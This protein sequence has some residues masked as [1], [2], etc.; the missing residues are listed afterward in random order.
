M[1]TWKQFYVEH[2]KGK[3]IKKGELGQHM[4]K[5]GEM[6]R[7]MKSKKGGEVE[8]VPDELKDTAIE[9]GGKMEPMKKPKS[10]KPVKMIDFSK[11]HWGMFTKDWKKMGKNFPTLRDFA[12]AVL[13]SP[14]GY[15]EITVKRARFYKNIL[16]KG[17]GLGM[18]M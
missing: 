5:V 8:V 1:T 4:K 12:N 18:C 17:K 9:E 6:W 3:A 7:E 2:T 11:I 14:K 10:Q 16:V 13:K 15:P